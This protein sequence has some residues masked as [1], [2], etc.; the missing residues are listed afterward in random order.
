[1]RVLHIANFHLSL[2][3][4]HYNNCDQKINAGLIEAGHAVVSYSYKDMLRFSNV[5]GTSRFGHGKVRAQLLSIADAFQ[6]ECIVLGHAALG[7]LALG[8]IGVEVG[9]PLLQAA[10]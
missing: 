10:P 4:Q 9:E 7:L 3:G 2:N 5:L 6:P 1:M 8:R